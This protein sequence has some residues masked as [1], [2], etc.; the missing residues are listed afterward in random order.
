MYKIIYQI[1]LDYYLLLFYLKVKM[2]WRKETRNIDK[3][4]VIE[5]FRRKLILIPKLEI[6]YF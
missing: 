6:E 2:A 1:K 3:D 4:D 5:I